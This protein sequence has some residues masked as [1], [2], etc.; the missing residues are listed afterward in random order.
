MRTPS[1]TIDLPLSMGEQLTEREHLLVIE[2][3][4]IKR[5]NSVKFR[6]EVSAPYSITLGN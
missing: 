5:D 2:R 4:K 1:V 6:G 3:G